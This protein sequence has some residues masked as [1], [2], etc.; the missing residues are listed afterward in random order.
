[1]T[2]NLP[3]RLKGN[4]KCVSSNLLSPLGARNKDIGAALHALLTE[5]KL[6]LQC[7]RVTSGA[8]VE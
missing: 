4:L 7:S 8:N 3:I 2:G 1:M 6:H 5:V